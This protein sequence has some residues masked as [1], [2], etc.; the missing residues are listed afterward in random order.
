MGFPHPACL[1]TGAVCVRAGPLGLAVRLPTMTKWGRTGK[2]TGAAGGAKLTTAVGILALLAL[3]V[4]IAPSLAAAAPFLDALGPGSS[5][6]TDRVSAIVSVIHRY[7]W[8]VDGRVVRPFDPPPQ[9]WLSGHRGVDLVAEA[10][11]T[12]RAAGPGVVHFAGRIAG[13][14]VV[15]VF[16][17]GGLRTTYEPV[18]PLVSVGDR[19]AVGDPIG[20]LAAGHP[21]CP[22]A[23]CLHWGLRRGDEYLDPLMLLG[24]GRVRLLPVPRSRRAA[25]ARPVRSGRR[26]VDGR[27]RCPRS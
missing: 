7:Q 1:C 19:V 6:P 11:T 22:V 18:E 23:A 8:P 13:R 12:V 16:H 4:S 20:T 27:S 9:P 24:I 14:G 2:A 15:S 10:G 25:R 3:T 17:L 21:G 26:H 5:A